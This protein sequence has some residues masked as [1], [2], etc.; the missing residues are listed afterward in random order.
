MFPELPRQRAQPDHAEEDQPDD[1]HPGDDVPTFRG[2]VGEQREH[3]ASL[4]DPFGVQREGAIEGVVVDR[5]PR[6][7]IEH[8]RL[9]AF[10]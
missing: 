7:R 1:Q 4:A 10:P 9:P 5:L 2:G 8:R 6:K 3:G